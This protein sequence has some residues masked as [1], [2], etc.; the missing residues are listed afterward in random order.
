MLLTSETELASLL[1][2]KCSTELFFFFSSACVSIVR[3]Y[4]VLRAGIEKMC[5]KER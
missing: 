5:M 3:N 1:Y 4:I 2:L